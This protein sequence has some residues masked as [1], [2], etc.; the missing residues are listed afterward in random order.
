MNEKEQKSKIWND[1]GNC[2]SERE[3]F[4]FFFF[5][6]A[7]KELLEQEEGMESH[8]RDPSSKDQ[9]ENSSPSSSPISS[10]LGAGIIM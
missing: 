3:V 6:Y 9:A 1:R 4:F 2:N 10:K 8:T 7:E 5:C